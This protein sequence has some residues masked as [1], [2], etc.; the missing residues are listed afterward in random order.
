V[1]A[2]KKKAWR[3]KLWLIFLLLVLEIVVVVWAL[4]MEKRYFGTPEGQAL[5]AQLQDYR[6]KLDALG[7]LR[8]PVMVLIQI[9]QMILAL[10]PGGPLAF[11]LGFMFGTIGGAIVGT[12]GN[13]IGTAAI[14]WAVNRFG[15][16]FV[17]LFC[18]SKG[19]EKLKFL[20]DPKK[21]D[22][23]FF[24]VMLIPGTPKDLLTF[25]APFTKMKPGN[26]VWLACIARLP[27]LILST[28]VGANLAGGNLGATVILLSITLFV[29]VVGLLMKDRV[30]GGS[31]PDAAEQSNEV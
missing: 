17:N 20:H 9:L 22:L 26:I 1:E 25:F 13:V 5:S 8:Y 24:I 18:N 11:L 7:I 2:A 15:M 19:F 4:Y 30:M 16:K 6:G 10:I 14:V 23:L 12:I 28:S 29:S 31:E 27:A 21:R 3:Q